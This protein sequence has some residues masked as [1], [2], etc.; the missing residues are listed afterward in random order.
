MI[1]RRILVN[2]RQ[3][4]SRAFVI[5]LAL[6]PL[7]RA[8]A[9]AACQQW[10]VSGRWQMQQTNGFTVTVN[11]V[12]KG[13]KIL[14]RATTS[15]AGTHDV[16]GNVHG[17]DLYLDVTWSLETRGIYRGKI[18]SSGRIEGT[19]Y[20]KENPGSRAKWFST[21]PMRCA[22][23]SPTPPPI[24]STGVVTGRPKPSGAIAGK[25]RDPTAP[26]STATPAGPT[27]AT[28]P[29]AGDLRRVP[30]IVANVNPVIIPAGQTQGTT[31]LMWDGGKDHPYAEV[32]VKVDDGADTFVVEQGKGSRTVTVERGKRYLYILTDSGQRLATTTVT[33]K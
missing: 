22:D 4:I 13:T 18:G 30:G 6:A 26:W 14:G 31:T 28:T 7:G 29:R 27:P 2:R 19:T 16:R 11:L 21:T 24:A 20:D 3:L 12:Q 23:V 17:D 32:W 15:T 25:D 5:C 9:E 1:A 8:P 10:D 33:T